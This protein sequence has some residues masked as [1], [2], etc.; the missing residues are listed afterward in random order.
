MSA[1][2]KF[3]VVGGTGRLG[4]H[5]T[6][7]LAAAG[8]VVV[9]VARSTGVDVITGE[10]LDQAL[11]GASVAIDATSGRS[12]DQSEA[13]VFFRTAAGNL[14]KHGQRAGVRR[15]VTV[16]IIGTDLFSTGYNAAKQVH[17]QVSLAGPVPGCVLRAAQFHEFVP[18]LM[19]WGQ[20]GGVTYVPRMR[21]Q[22]VAARAVAEVV[23]DLAR[24][25]DPDTDSTIIEVAG[26]REERFADMA[27]LYGAATGLHG[28]VVEVDDP[29]D[30]D[31]LGAAGA[32][33]PH[34]GAQLV[35]PTFADWVSELISS[36]AG[37]D[38][39]RSRLDS[40]RSG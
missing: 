16:S 31:G 27:A 18:Q 8:E 36:P 3:V 6:D 34:P 25:P 26:P 10:G 30:P 22:L 21:T 40:A 7:L 39:V 9:P 5:V 1:R 37:L 4:W 2:A 13:T 33:L 24:S 35:G 28:S 14:Q 38:R 19:E 11:D 12:A 15:I 17:E 32:L 29:T 20:H 23:V